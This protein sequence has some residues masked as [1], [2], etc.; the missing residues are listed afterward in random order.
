[1]VVYDNGSTDDT[2]DIVATYKNVK[3]YSGGFFGFGETKNY[4]V[5]LATNDMV[6]V[7]DS[8]EVATKELVYEIFDSVG[9]VEFTVFEVPRLNNFFGKNI[10]YGGLYP[11][12]SIRV[13]DRKVARFDNSIVHEKVVTK[14]KIGRLKHHMLHKAYENI[15]Q[16]IDKQNRYSTLRAKNNLFKALT[17][18]IWTFL[19]MYIFRLGFLDGK[20]GFII[21]TLYS[22]YTFWK[23]IK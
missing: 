9:K 1:V 23:Y 3:L 13:F 14:E 15:E 4:A 22:Q 18:P 10:R 2:K 17:S 5:S 16:F 20:E 6:F 21:A 19:K 8:D 11:D 7:I 12:Y